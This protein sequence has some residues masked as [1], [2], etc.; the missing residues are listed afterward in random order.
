MELCHL[1]SSTVM[2]DG[3][4]VRSRIQAKYR[5]C[6]ARIELHVK[7][8]DS[9]QIAQSPTSTNSFEQ[10]G[11]A[12]LRHRI[13]ICWPVLATRWMSTHAANRTIVWGPTIQG[14]RSYSNLNDIPSLS[15][16]IFLQ[17][18]DPRTYLTPRYKC[19]RLLEGRNLQLSTLTGIIHSN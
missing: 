2:I 6:W 15:P 14:I 7:P 19:N 13:F 8:T 3:I 11:D 16:C 1:Q 5:V 9:A 18:T 4:S 10:N 17:V 12:S